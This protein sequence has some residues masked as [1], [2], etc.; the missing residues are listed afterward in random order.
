MKLK[1][2]LFT[3]YQIYH[4][5]WAYRL[6]PLLVTSIPLVVV[7]VV[8]LASPKIFSVGW[9]ILL[10]IGISVMLLIIGGLLC[11]LTLNASIFVAPE[12]LLYCG[13]GTCVY[14]PWNNIEDTEKKVMGAFTIE[15][16]RLRRA[17]ADAPSLE[18]GI[19]QHMPVI[20][21]VAFIRT[22]EEAQ[23]TMRRLAL[24]FSLI[25]TLAGGR[26]RVFVGRATNPPPQ[27]YIPV[28]LFGTSWKYG[29]LR[30]EIGRYRSISK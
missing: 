26:A 25:T 24:I 18:E 10:L 16:L 11:L 22:A 29:K 19:Q 14:T 2:G 8:A 12:G 21:K 9:I 15:N 3:S 27:K 5:T 30:D 28:G 4:A 1:E 13:M 23:P 6:S 20:T 7:W 17:A